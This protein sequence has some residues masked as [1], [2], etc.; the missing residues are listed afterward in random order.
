MRATA[1]QRSSIQLLLAVVI[2]SITVIIACS[3]PKKIT[4]S[5]VRPECPQDS[6][7]IYVEN[8]EERGTFLILSSLTLAGDHA[9]VP[10]YND[11]QRFIMGSGN[12]YG[13][14]VAIWAAEHLDSLQDSL[15]QLQENMN[16]SQMALA[17]AEIHNYDAAY[18]PL[19][20]QHDFSCLYVWTEL[21]G[22]QNPASNWRARIVPVGPNEPNC[23][24]PVP[25]DSLGG[26]E[27]QV[28][29]DSNA[30]L[31]G[32][33]V[34]PVARWDWDSVHAQ[35][36]I[37]I[38]CGR[39]WC[40][41]GAPDFV[42]SFKRALTLPWLEVRNTSVPSIT[43]NERQRVVEVK[44]WYDD[45]RL[46]VIGSS[47]HPEPTT[48]LGTAYPHPALQR[49]NQGSI[50]DEWTPSAMVNVEAEYNG[51]L[52]LNRGLNEVYL[53]GG[54]KA[55]CHVPETTS[56]CSPENQDPAH[57]WWAMIIAG[58]DTTY[59]CVMRRDHGIP[60]IPGTVRWR[61]SE[62]DE[63]IWVRCTTGCCTVS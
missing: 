17:A 55:H 28:Q 63:K 15:Q 13:P 35:Q 1:K 34:P 4:A 49:L 25:F 23:A 60:N 41:V 6:I 39:D 59:H 53:C 21:I 58:T 57:P 44:G 20:I 9:K 7:A 11:C 2:V 16:N 22:S 46:A 52:H 56:T 14:L 32:N 54:N 19:H 61:W 18:A 48:V 27:L 5:D 51:K 10:E 26:W 12:T 43:P 40:N 50:F 33:D 36:S 31:S 3:S 29:V 24:K 37:G 30:H 62:N 38:K 45:Q 42:A 47:G 8:P